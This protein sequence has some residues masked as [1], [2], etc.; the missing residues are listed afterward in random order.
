[1]SS[2]SS[3]SKRR[4]ARAATPVTASVRRHGDAAAASASPSHDGDAS[5]TALPRVAIVGRPNAGKSTLFNRLL[6]RRKALVDPTPGV[7]RDANEAVAIFDD[8]AVLLVDTGGFEAEGAAGLDVAVRERSL[9]AIVDA[10]LVVYVLDGKAGLSAADEAAA[11]ELR[12]RGARVVFVV[13][14]LDSARREATAGEFYRLGAADLITV[15]AEHGHGIAELIEAILARVPA[16][17]APVED[18]AIR[19]GIIGRPNVGKSSLVNRLLG[20]ARTLVHERAG[21]TRDAV[22]TLLEADGARYVLVDT[23]GLRR[24]ARIHERRDPSNIPSA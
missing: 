4:T 15:S 24:R 18:A 20:Y 11:R 12:R 19:V 1:M 14:K 17:T 7:T 2:V 8:R 16:A 22:D 5:T 13:N 21:T 6:R 3:G 23:A 9:A 10:A